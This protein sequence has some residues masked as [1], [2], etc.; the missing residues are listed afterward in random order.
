[1]FASKIFDF[2]YP[3]KEMRRRAAEEEAFKMALVLGLWASAK[4]INRT[5]E[6]TGPWA[7]G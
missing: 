7:M 2:W 4:M 3:N 6:C 5:A 1:M